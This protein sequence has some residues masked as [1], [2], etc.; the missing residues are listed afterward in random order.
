DAERVHH[1]ELARPW[2]GHGGADRVQ[3]QRRGVSRFLPGGGH[4]VG[5]RDHGRA[6]YRSSSRS[7]VACNRS[8]TT[9]RNRVVSSRPS[10]GSRWNSARTA[11]ASS[12]TVIV[13][14]TA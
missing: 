14:S 1:A 10:A 4:P 12:C 6:W 9:C 2:G 8:T 13:V 3:G 7:R 5:Q 11:A